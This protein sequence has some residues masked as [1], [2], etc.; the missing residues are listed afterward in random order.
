MQIG[1]TSAVVTG[2]ASGLGRAVAE[3]LAANGANVAILDRNGAAAEA[4]AGAIGGLAVEVDVTSEEDV[5]RGFAAA[6]A[7]H[8]QERILV[9]CA[10]TG[11]SMR[12][13]SRSSDG[14]TI[15]RLPVELFRTILDVNLLGTFRCITESAS[16]MLATATADVEGERG[17]V[18]TTSSISAQDGQIG[19]AAYAASKAA[20]IAMTPIMARDLAREGVRVNC[21]LPGVFETPP[22]A[23]RHTIDALEKIVPFPSR[24]GR[25]A[26]FASLVLE[27]CRNRYMNGANI[28]LDGALTLTAPPD[29][30]TP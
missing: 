23:G 16:G 8:G 11:K 1:G 29:R 22:V 30:R 26:E 20:I 24:L 7:R 25:P 14:T 17:V 18:V 6:R 9:C 27:I 10:G 12:I 13:V 2:G 21:I 3:A 4:V 5:T 28:R 15:R 19:T